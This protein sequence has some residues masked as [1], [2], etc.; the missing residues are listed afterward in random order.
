MCNNTTNH[1]QT[2][3]ILLAVHQ[4]KSKCSY[5]PAPQVRALEDAGCS[6][7]S[8]EGGGLRGQTT[9]TLYYPYCNFTFNAT[10]CF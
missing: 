10:A 4:D 2:S 9:R 8:R 5:V 6:A 3:Y 1:E 7:A